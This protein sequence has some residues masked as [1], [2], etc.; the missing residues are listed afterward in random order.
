M[1]CLGKPKIGCP[2]RQFFC[3]IWGGLIPV[4]RFH[5][6]GSNSD[7]HKRQYGLDVTLTHNIDR[8][9]WLLAQTAGLVRLKKRLQVKN[10]PKRAFYSHNV[11]DGTSLLHC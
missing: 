11:P 7:L 6:P 4:L 1:F 9:R 3:L 2:V 10:T 8:E 5:H